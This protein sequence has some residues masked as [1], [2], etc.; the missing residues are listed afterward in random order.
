MGYF[1]HHPASFDSGLGASFSSFPRPNAFKLHFDG[2]KIKHEPT[3][4]IAIGS[5][6][7][8]QEDVFGKSAASQSWSDWLDD[9]EEEEELER[10]QKAERE[11]ARKFDWSEEDP[12]FDEEIDN[13][14]DIEWVGG[15][16]D[17]LTV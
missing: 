2:S 9:D 3:Q 6:P 5:K 11:N 16:W 7:L 12:G 14:Y 4:A 1:N 13:G 10:Q 17:D 8:K 15:G